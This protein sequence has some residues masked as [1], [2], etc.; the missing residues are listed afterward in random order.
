MSN[1]DIMPIPRQAENLPKR[2]DRIELREDAY[3]HTLRAVFGSNSNGDEISRTLSWEP[4]TGQYH[5]EGKVS[6]KATIINILSRWEA[7]FRPADFEL[8][9]GQLGV[10]QESRVALKGVLSNGES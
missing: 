5:F 9:R 3:R 1:V 4:Q 6:S 7:M 8:M 2:L 10:A